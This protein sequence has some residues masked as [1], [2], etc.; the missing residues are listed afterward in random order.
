MTLIDRRSLLRAGL[1]GGVLGVLPA[2]PVFAGWS[3]A[4]PV[5][6]HGVQT[7]DATADAAVV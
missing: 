6:T 2:G 4:R 5:L 3:A 7:G 1:A